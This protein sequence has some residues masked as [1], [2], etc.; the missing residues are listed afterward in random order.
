MPPSS[1]NIFAFTASAASKSSLNSFAF[2]VVPKRMQNNSFLISSSA[3]SGVD[4]TQVLSFP[5][6]LCKVVPGMIKKF[7]H[8][9][10]SL[11]RRINTLVFFVFLSS[12]ILTGPTP[13]SFHSCFSK[14]Y[15]YSFALYS[16]F[17]TSDSSPVSVDFSSSWTIGL[18]SAWHSS[19]GFAAAA[20]EASLF[21]EEAKPSLAPKPL[22]PVPAN[23]DP[24]PKIGVGATFGVSSPLGSSAMVPSYFV[25]FLLT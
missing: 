15:R 24:C 3:K 8:T 25:F 23:V 17:I 6:W 12:K 9:F 20:L 1:S 19:S 21:A 18:N 5:W 16:S 13:L 2:S 7:A 11:S 14:S 4:Q 22:K 10:M